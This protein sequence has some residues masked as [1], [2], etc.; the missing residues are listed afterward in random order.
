MNSDN[1]PFRTV[2]KKF[3]SKFPELIK[4]LLEELGFTL[5]LVEEKLGKI[6]DLTD[7]KGD[8]SAKTQR[9]LAF[10]LSHISNLC[11]LIR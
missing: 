11:S 9:H 4:P 2:I 10:L 5:K 6:K 8:N 3:L 1:V 7:Y